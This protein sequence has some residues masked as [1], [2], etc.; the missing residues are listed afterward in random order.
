[1]SLFNNELGVVYGTTQL[2]VAIAKQ[3]QTLGFLFMHSLYL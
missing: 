1:M 3:G 2:R